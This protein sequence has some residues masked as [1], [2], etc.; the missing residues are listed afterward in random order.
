[1]TLHFLYVINF[2]YYK[3]IN[4]KIQHNQIQNNQIQNSQI[5]IN[6]K[7][8]LLMNVM[9]SQQEILQKLILSNKKKENSE[10]KKEIKIEIKK[11]EKSVQTEKFP[12]I[13]HSEQDSKQCSFLYP[14]IPQSTKIN[15]INKN[16]HNISM[17]YDMLL[18]LINAA[19]NKSNK[20]ENEQTNII[21]PPIQHTPPIQ[22][23]HNV[24]TMHLQSNQHPH[25]QCTYH[26]NKNNANML[27]PKSTLHFSD[28]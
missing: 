11:N 12:H 20:N 2:I 18:K 13:I 4:N 15:N 16:N 19:T 9:H 7:L 27:S 3:N 25:P 14:P 10:N 1:M 24:P 28:F 23:M 26:P 8:D 22:A 17:P 5:Q 6:Q 21:P